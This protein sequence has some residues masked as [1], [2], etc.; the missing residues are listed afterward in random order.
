MAPVILRGVKELMP[1]WQDEAFAFLA[2]SMIVDDE[3]EAVKISNRGR[4]DYR[5]QFS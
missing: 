3:E 4:Y 1:V 2:A 5:H